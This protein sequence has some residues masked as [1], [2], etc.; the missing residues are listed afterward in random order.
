M[1]YG[2]GQW[3]YSYQGHDLIEH[4]GS[5]PGYKTQVARFPDD[6]LGIITLSNDE[7]FGEFIQDAVKFRI[8]D[9]ILGLK[10]VNWNDRREKEWNKHVED[11]Q[12]ITPRPA[13]PKAPSA[14]FTSLA[15]VTFSHP[16][17]GTL[18]P[19]LV[20]ASVRLSS[21]SLFEFPQ[22]VNLLSSHSV[23]RILAAS[24]LSIPTYIISWKRFLATHLRL[25]HFNENLFNVTV[26]W[27]NSEIRE[28]EG[29]LD[30]EG[31]LLTGLDDQY[32]VEW[33]HGST[34]Q[35]EEGLAFKGGFWGKGVDA[36]S[37]NGVG[38]ESAEV[39]FAKQ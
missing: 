11:A 35:E 7:S 30:G 32:E 17:Y 24:D 10:E 20:P 27:S 29:Y 34:G 4:G 38:K 19:C 16:S 12:R 25:A 15:E 33:V 18:Q 1:V 23:Q 9:D 8:A 36:P 6:N 31:D 22:C 21:D 37:L 2:A 3:R 14:P 5:N 26:I 13:T 28:K 39:W